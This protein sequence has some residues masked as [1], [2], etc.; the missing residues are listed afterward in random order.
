[1]TFQV[2][3]EGSP[4]PRCL[5]FA[6]PQERQQSRKPSGWLTNRLTDFSPQ[7]TI[8]TCRR[9]TAEEG[10]G[11]GGKA[12]D[13]AHVQFGAKRGGGGGGAAISEKLSGGFPDGRTDTQAPSRTLRRAIDTCLKLRRPFPSCGAPSAPRLLSPWAR[14]AR[15]RHP[16]WLS[17][18]NNND[19]FLCT[20]KPRVL[21]GAVGGAVRKRRRRVGSSLVEVFFLPA[22]KPAGEGSSIN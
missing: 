2:T 15:A 11:K 21:G 10:R 9:T 16:T 19:V 1:M 5:I 18:A 17:G 7:R 6:S 14:P 3:Q 22:R 13:H 4:A 12:R 20:R 8:K